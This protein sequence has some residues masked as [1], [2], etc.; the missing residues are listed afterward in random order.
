MGGCRLSGRPEAPLAARGGGQT[1]GYALVAEVRAGDLI[2]HYNSN[3]EVVVGVSR[4]N[5]ERFNEPI[6]WAARG[7]YA[8]RAHVQAAWLPGITVALEGFVPLATPLSLDAI[9]S[10]RGE[11]LALRGDLAEAHPGQ[12]LYFPWIPY[13][14]SLRTFQSYLAKFPQAAL[15]VLPE[16]AAAVVATSAPG[17]TDREQPEIDEAERD[18][19]RAAGKPRPPRR[20]R[21]Q[22][23][24]VDQGAKVAIEAHAM[25]AARAHYSTLGKVTDESRTE[26]YDYRVEIDADE[27]HVEVK[28]TTGD[29]KQILLTP[30]EVEHAQTYP[31]V[32]LF[33]L[34]RIKVTREEDGTVVTSGGTATIRHPWAIDPSG[35]EPLGYMYRL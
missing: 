4:A 22:G 5:G 21:G 8:Q 19:A 27:W 20:G 26:R 6:W 35:L 25:N 3:A 7:S 34:S 10:R 33:I 32:A 28:G 31:R 29:A 14:D 9:R 24:A 2:V 16:V 12:S 17:S 1:P 23:F 15:A 11:L 30:N 13:R 18:V